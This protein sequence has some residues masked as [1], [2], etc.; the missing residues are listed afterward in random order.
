[1]FAAA[2]RAI[3]ANARSYAT[4]A[5]GVSAEEAHAAHATVTWKRISLFVA[6]PAVLLATANAV[7][8]H[9]EHHDYIAYPHLRI[10]NKAFPWSDS[11]H[12]LFHNPHTNH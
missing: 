11:D 10:R 8:A 1:M 12:S 6:F 2:A 9:E 3:A 7:A 5:A 4:A